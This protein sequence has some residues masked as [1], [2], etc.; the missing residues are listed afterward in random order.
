MYYYNYTAIHSKGSGQ[1]SHVEN[2]TIATAFVL[3]Y[4]KVCTIQ[5]PYCL[6]IRGMQKFQRNTFRGPAKIDP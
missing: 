5:W 2:H 1:G 6:Q 3:A 4:L